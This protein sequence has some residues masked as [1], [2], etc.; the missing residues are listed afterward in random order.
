MAYEILVFFRIKNVSEKVEVVNE[1]A[2]LNILM[3]HSNRYV[4]FVSNYF[5]IL[6]N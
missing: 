5:A 1:V 4:L 2:I 6:L 3:I